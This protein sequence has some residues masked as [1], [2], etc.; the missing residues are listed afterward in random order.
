MIKGSRVGALFGEMKNVFYSFLFRVTFRIFLV[1]LIILSVTGG[2]RRKFRI[3]AGR[4]EGI[5]FRVFGLFR[6]FSVRFGVTVFFGVFGD[7]LG[8]TRAVRLFV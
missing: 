1:M 8:L 4:T 5:L 3:L 2:I 6:F 7:G